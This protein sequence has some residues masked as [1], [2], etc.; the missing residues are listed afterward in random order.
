MH[1]RT[2]LILGT[3]LNLKTRCGCEAQSWAGGL[4]ATPLGA[5]RVWRWCD[6]R[7]GRGVLYKRVPVRAGPFASATTYMKEI[8]QVTGFS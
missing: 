3:N 7:R 4:N 8:V 1:V 2:F 5:L 6:L